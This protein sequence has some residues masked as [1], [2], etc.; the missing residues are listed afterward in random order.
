[1]KKFSGILLVLMAFGLQTFGTHILGGELTYKYLG[2]NGPT[3]R[4]FRYLIHFVGYVDRVGTPGQLS[5]WGCGNLAQDPFLAIYD[6]GTNERIQ[7]DPNAQPFQLDLI[8]WRLP[9]HGDQIQ[10][11]C[12]IDPYFGGMRPLVI[13]VPASCVVPGLTELNIAITDTTFEVQLPLSFS[14]YKVKYEN[15]C[16]T[17]N[18]TNILFPG[19]NN[20]PGNTW[21]ATIP[22]PIFANSSPQFIGDAVPFFCKGDTATISNNAFD[23]DGDRLIYSFATPYSGD[24]GN[25]NVTYSDPAVATYASGFSQSQPFGPGGIAY[26]NPSTGLTKYYC[27]VNGNYAVAVDIQEYR[28]L[29]N[30]S[31]ILLSTTRREFLVVVKACA[32]NPPPDPEP[33]SGTVN[34]TTFIRSEGD[35]VVFEVK[36]FDVDTT[37]ITAE[38]ELFSSSTNT[39]SLAVC[40]SVTGVDSVKTK[41]SWKINCGITGGIVRNYSVVVRY[42]DKGCPPKTSTVIYTIIVNPF[43]APTITGRDSICSTDQ[44]ISYNAPAG[45]GRQWK[46]FGGNIVG[47]STNSSVNVTIPGDTARIRLVVTSGLGCK[48]SS[49]KKIQRFQLVPILATTATPFVC[50]DSSISL[51]A[52]GGY[53]KVNWTPTT[54]LSSATIRTPKAT[55]SDTSDYVVTS[56]GPGGCIAKDTVTVR[57]IPRIANAGTDSILCSSSSRIIGQNQPIGYKYYQYQWTPPAGL[58]SDTSFR[59][60][61]TLTNNGSSNQVF[62][63]V[64]KA[65]HRESGCLS[66]DTVRLSVKP[67]PVVNAGPDTA[68]ICSGAKTIIGTE[69]SES[70]TYSWFPVNGLFSPNQ[71]TTT[72]SLNPDSVNPQFIRYYLTKTEVLISPLDGEPSCVNSD[73]IL[74]RINPLPFFDLSDKDSICSGLSTTI[75]T[76]GVNGFAYAWSPDRGLS[77]NTSA[78]TQ[79]SLTNLTQNPGD[80]LYTLLVINSSTTCSREK[81]INIRV[82]PLPIVR[83]GSDTTLCSGDSIKIGESQQTGF[84]YLWTPTS[85]LNSSVNPNPLISLVNPNVGGAPQIF[86]Y[87]LVKTDD[88]TKCVNADSLNVK[89]KA[90]PTV[91]AGPDTATICSGLKTVI[92]FAES[93][94][95]IYQ[96]SPLNGLLN[97]TK[98]T[99]TVTLNPDSLAPQFYKY[100]VK[101]TE[102]IVLPGEPACSNSDS[103]VLRVNPLP[104]FSLASKDSICSGFA[105]Q[106]GTNNQD[107]FQYVWSPTRGLTK[108]DSSQTGI[109]LVNLSQTPGDTVYSLLVTNQNTTCQ[110]TKDINIRVNPLPVVNAGLDSAFCSGDSIRIGE[111]NVNG[112]SYTWSPSTGLSSGSSSGPNVS[113]VNPNT[114]GASTSFPYKLVKLNNQTTCRNADSLILTVKPLPIAIAAGSDT[115]AVCSKSAIQIGSDALADHLYSWVPDTALNQ[116]TISN[117]LV[118]IQNPTQTVRY[119]PYKVKVTNTVT[120]CKNADSVMVQVN[121]LPIVP[122]SYADTSVCSKDTIRIGGST[123]GGYS[124]TWSPKAQLADSTISLTAFTA[125]NNTDAPVTYTFN[126]LVNNDGTGCKDNKSVNVKVNP[127]PDADAGPDKEVCSLDS[128]QLGLPPVAGRKYSWSPV[129]GL[130]NPDV[131]NPKLSLVNNGT[132]NTTATYVLTVTDILNPTQCDSSDAV[133]VTIKPLP[134]AVAFALDTAKVCATNGI[135]LGVTPET[136]YSYSWSPS[137][138]LSQSDVSNPVFNSTTATG[139]ATL[140]YVVTVINTL[141]TCQK[142]DSVEILVN[143]LPVVNVGSLDSLCSNDTINIGPG[144]GFVPLQYVWTPTTGF[145]GSNP[146]S[147][148]LTLVNT[149]STVVVNPY[150]LILTNTQTGCRDSSTLQ[151][152]VNPLPAVNAGSDKVICSGESV[153]VGDASQLGNAY[154]WVSGTG[155]NFLNISDPVFTMTNTGGPRK[156]TLVVQ[157][158]NSQTQCKRKDSA[159]VTT[160]P[161]PVPMTFGLYSGTVC[162]FTP[163][164]N[165]SVTN[166]ILGNTYLWTVSG[167]SLISGSGTNS[168]S[169]NWNGPNPNAKIVVTPTNIFGCEGPK[170]SIQLVL[171]QNLK[172]QKPLGDSV[173]CSFAKTSKFYSTVPTPGS[174]YT[175]RLVGASVDSIVSADGTATIDWTVNN[176]FTKIWIDQQSSTIDPVTSTPVQCYGQSDT[177]LVRINP[178]PDSTLLVNGLN[179][180]CGQ[181]S[182]T[183]EWYSLN[184]FSG[185]SYNWNVNPQAGIVAGQGSD[186]LQI[187]WVDSGTYLVS[188]VETSDKGCVGRSRATSVVV[189][190]LPSPRLVNL[191]SLTICPNDLQKGYFATSATGFDNSTF[192]WTVSGGTPSTP[193]N[194]KFLGV[195]WSEAGP[196]GLT[197]TETTTAGCSKD[198]VIS[199]IADPSSLVMK[200]VSLFEADEN[201][202]KIEFDMT[203]QASNP[204]EISVWRKEVG[205]PNSTWSVIKSGIAKNINSYIDEPG[206]TSTK[207]YQYKV[208]G[209]NVCAKGIE[210]DVHNT[211]LLNVTPL[212]VSDSTKLNWNAYI[213]WPDNVKSYS[214]L[215]KLDNENSL[216]DYESGIAASQKPARGYQNASDGFKHCYRIESFDNSGQNIS[217]S[218]TVCVTFDNPLGFFNLITPNGD[219]KNDKW[220]IKNLHLYPENELMIFD[221]WGR[222][223]FSRNN[224]NNSDLWSADDQQD[225]VYFYKF[226]VPSKGLTFQG[227]LTV[228]KD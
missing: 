16:R 134:N 176:G 122:L 127:L 63:F 222:K 113:L 68:V 9:S 36:S 33:I 88:K 40:P 163:N 70:A 8:N 102:G 56:S 108:T 110:R 202:V 198:T 166:S 58:Q 66:T 48:D 31:E 86:P 67:L 147:Q 32:D 15:C 227:W 83:A 21:L 180:V 92:G 101:K 117:P 171:N 143:P 84:S 205:A 138:N 10:G 139:S 190:P 188:V 100:T 221:R 25:P 64:Q 107:G 129:T 97:P 150:K 19:G 119:L 220:S 193:L 189:N 11:P 199:L 219:D 47:S 125:V 4:P 173:L 116:I 187:S 148:P 73:S 93:V 158:T 112:Y 57:W 168:I 140:Q 96:W 223:I 214:V 225:G 95:A 103:I 216:V 38:S 105:T 153:S 50:Q 162:P 20:N 78:Q 29:S 98:D 121:P 161:R 200:N 183:N 204:G 43:K 126:L 65:T 169:V 211:I 30:G 41:F 132:T 185:S 115:V 23:P 160:N 203:S 75:G 120:T 44:T 52:V 159:V 149:G 62:T 72:V 218:N 152:R 212:Q 22:S 184:G 94:S 6:A 215:R 42:A 49:S 81:T 1:M 14:G 35:S 135:D 131:A 46:L 172:P 114:G 181:P 179:S 106:I 174:N 208:S 109:S 201:Q 123:V 192:K 154:N 137:A 177:L 118:N 175:W 69:E 178:S 90:L 60:L 136:G 18:T 141:N 37:T 146:I 13:P 99:T 164:V 53:T 2:S 144:T 145:I 82:N 91:S 206:F 156:D 186:S 26:I 89:V 34:G 27:N 12:A 45:T 87:K 207:A 226:M 85:G 191:T 133:T 195:N 210:S 5:N 55:V 79:I 165:Y 155:L 170:D 182:G 80:T 194:D 196:Y 124:Y 71:D 104:F 61:A 217:L 51:N 39:G 142:K 130:S 17:E 28:T 209:T 151:V 74:L 77:N 54:G 228:R 24:G 59:T 111:V 128:V 7:K 167:G 224:Y 157:M 3:D 76:T 197:L 213:G